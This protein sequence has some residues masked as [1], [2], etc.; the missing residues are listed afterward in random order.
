[1][2]ILASPRPDGQQRVIY[3]SLS[4]DLTKKNGGDYQECMVHVAH[5]SLSKKTVFHQEF[6]DSTNLFLLGNLF[7]PPP[8]FISCLSED[9]AKIEMEICGFNKNLP[10]L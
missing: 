3:L 7:D 1:M 8:L 5:K 4:K 6:G 10:D 2:Q 9:S